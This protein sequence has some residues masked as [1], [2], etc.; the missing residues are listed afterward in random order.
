MSGLTSRR[1]FV[2]G[3]R[4]L[5]N[6]LLASTLRKET[7]LSCALVEDLAR[8]RPCLEGAEKSECL[9][10]CDCLGRDPK[11]HLAGLEEGG[12]RPGLML[13]LFNLERGGGLE[14]DAL[15]RGVRG[16]FYRDEPFSLLAKGVLRI[17]EGELWI[18]RLLLS[19]LVAQKRAASRR[20]PEQA[21]SR[22]ENEI[23]G[24]LARGTTNEEI[25]DAMFISRHTVKN[26]LQRIFR[27]IHVHSKTQA[28]LWAARHLGI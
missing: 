23:L 22:R 15:S 27:K 9:A 24:L 14:K 25:A 19:E 5:Q 12:S 28:A 13:G 20:M 17:L 10:L 18:P 16:F 6:K 2:A 1:V 8:I 11:A 21:L 7:R 26:H 3:P 4:T